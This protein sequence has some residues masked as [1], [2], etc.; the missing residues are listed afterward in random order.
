MNQE[1]WLEYRRSLGLPADPEKDFPPSFRNDPKTYR[2]PDVSRNTDM[3]E[4]QRRKAEAN[5]AAARRA[6]NAQLPQPAQRPQPTRR[7]QGPTANTKQSSQ[8]QQ[9]MAEAMRRFQQNSGGGPAPAGGG[10]GRPAYGGGQP[11]PGPPKKNNSSV[12]CCLVLVIIAIVLVISFVAPAGRGIFDL[13]NASSGSSSGNS[14]TSYAEKRKAEEAK[15]SKAAQ[16]KAGAFMDQFVKGDPAAVSVLKETGSSAYD[17]GL[18]TPQQA[19]ASMGADAKWTQTDVSLIGSM[20]TIDGFI[21]TSSDRI[22]VKLRLMRYDEIWKPQGL[23]MPIMRAG[24]GRLPNEFKVNGTKVSIRDDQVYSGFLVWPGTTKVEL[25]TDGE[26][27]YL[28]PKQTLKATG[29]VSHIGISQTLS[30]D[31][32]QKY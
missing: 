10:P 17:F 12:G 26:I 4:R 31:V 13:F 27:T 6:S 30:I 5:Q 7:P 2:G 24:N 11:T 28:N 16:A 18:L 22:P 21:L 3:T 19:K 9:A 32:S 20:A 29:E 14:Y 8:A 1:E 25:P 15:Q 23:R